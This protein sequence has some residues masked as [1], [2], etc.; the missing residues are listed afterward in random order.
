VVVREHP[1]CWDHVWLL[2]LHGHGTIA[3][4]DSCLPVCLSASPSFPVSLYSCVCVCVCVLTCMYTC[5]YICV[6]CAVR[7]VSQL[8]YK[9]KSWCVLMDGQLLIY[10]RATDIKPKEVVQLKS[11][12][13]SVADKVVG[14]KLNGT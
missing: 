11:C 5:T 7:Q 9:K 10:A 6:W 13:S 4:T 14:R 12:Y 8:S 2:A 1:S 3:L